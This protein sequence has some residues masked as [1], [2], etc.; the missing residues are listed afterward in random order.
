MERRTFF[1]KTAGAI[2]GA[3]LMS[4]IPL[5]SRSANAPSNRINIGVIGVGFGATN[6]RY[7]IEAAPGVHCTALCDVNRPRLEEQAVELKSR[8]PDKTA[9]MKLYD[10]FRK[11]FEDKDIDGVIIAT[12]NHWHNYIF[13]QACKAGKAIYVEKPTGHTVGDCNVM[14]DLQRKYNNVVSTGLWQ[15]SL[16]YFVE[17]FYILK[18]GVLGDVRK[19]HAWIYGGTD[20]VIYDPTPQPVPAGFDYE[21]WSGPAPLHPYVPE[22]V[23]RWN[24]YWDYAG[25]NQTNWVHYLDSALDGIAALGHKRTYPNSICSVGYKHPK[26]MTEVPATQT[27]V[28]QFD[29]LHLVWEEAPYRMYNRRDGAA[30]IGSKGTLVCNRTGYE[31]LPDRGRDGNREPLIEP[32]KKEGAYGNQYNHMINWAQCIRDNNPKTNSPVDK[33]GYATR[34]ANI[35]NISYR[36]GGQSLEYLPDERKFRNNPKADALI[37]NEYHNNW[38][39]PKI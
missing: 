24:G 16:E 34:L 21:M 28:F 8:F 17:A 20:P 12:P 35:A 15:A 19:V 36:L 5:Q 10:D 29:D 3:G 27:S 1:K 39:Y 9:N 6:M 23:N 37:V 18:S 11:L 22:R 32:V 14:D 26:S 38:K 33:G 31:I 7:M 2:A 4:S 30:W 13:A 25:G